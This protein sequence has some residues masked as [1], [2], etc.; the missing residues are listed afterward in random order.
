[1]TGSYASLQQL[2]HKG[3]YRLQE[4]W[5][6]LPDEQRADAR[7]IRAVL[8]RAALVLLAAGIVLGAVWANQSWGSYWTWDPKET[9][10]L[11]TWLA[12]AMPLHE[13]LAPCFRH[14]AWRSIYLC[15]AFGI[16]LMTYFGV[17]CWLGGLHS[18][19]G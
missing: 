11:I 1:M 14:R 5:Q 6:Q 2:Y 4:L 12:Y 10:A 8:L 18:Y 19:G 15:A 16:L 17:N 3:S 13:G 9:W 7:A